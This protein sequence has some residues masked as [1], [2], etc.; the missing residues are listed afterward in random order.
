MSLINNITI[1]DIIKNHDILNEIDNMLNF[2]PY[3]TIDHEIFQLI[4]SI[5]GSDLLDDEY[6][7]QYQQL[8]FRV[9]AILEKIV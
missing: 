8:K 6:Y 4:P 1:A 2:M 5:K 3:R 9:S 7:S